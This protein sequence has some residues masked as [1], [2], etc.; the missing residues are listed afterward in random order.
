MPSTHLRS[1]DPFIGQVEQTEQQEQEAQHDDES[2]E[3]APEE[4]PVSG[5]ATASRTMAISTVSNARSDRS[6]APRAIVVVISPSGGMVGWYGPV[7]W[8]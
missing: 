5:N 6:S 1:G 3:L 8:M 7:T 4:A 2:Q